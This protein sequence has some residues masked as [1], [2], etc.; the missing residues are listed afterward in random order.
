MYVHIYYLPPR[1][2]SLT[3]ISTM[4][5]CEYADNIGST[6]TFVFLAN[7]H[8][9]QPYTLHCKCTIGMHRIAWKVLITPWIFC[10]LFV[11]NTI[12]PNFQN[13]HGRRRQLYP[14]TCNHTPEHW[15]W[16][17]YTLSAWAALHP[18]KKLHVKLADTQCTQ[19]YCEKSRCAKAYMNVG[20]NSKTGQLSTY[21]T[22]VN[23]C[24]C[25]HQAHHC[26]L[27]SMLY[28]HC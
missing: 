7:V 8:F 16:Y 2:T 9:M 10:V 4:L 12:S 27:H 17:T 3:E 13:F 11:L 20:I 19:I 18:E 22:I 15:C 25:Q 24:M 23:A 14:F 21:T 6:A 1:Y 28:H 26:N 5:I